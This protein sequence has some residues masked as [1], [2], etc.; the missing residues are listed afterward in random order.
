MDRGAPRRLANA[1]GLSLE[2]NRDGGVRRIQFR[3][4]VV[5][6]FMGNGMEPGP[7][8][9][10][11][12]L[13]RGPRV[14]AVPLLGPQ[15]PLRASASRGRDGFQSR[16][17]W[18]GLGIALRLVLAEHEATWCW[19]V[20]LENRSSRKRTVDL[21]YGQD[22]ALASLGAVRLNEHYVSH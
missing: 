16:G 13:R 17:E 6:L 9:V 21:L 7:T 12:R 1:A 19:Q 3:D 11:L 22:L 8:N 5:N 4:D 18:Q 20:R 2:L 10:W 14:V 15:S